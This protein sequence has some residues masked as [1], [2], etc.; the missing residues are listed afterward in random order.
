MHGVLLEVFIS[1]DVRFVFLKNNPSLLFQEFPEY[2]AR[3]KGK[4]GLLSASKN[5]MNFVLLDP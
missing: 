4:N 1:C 2:Q 3:L 5:K